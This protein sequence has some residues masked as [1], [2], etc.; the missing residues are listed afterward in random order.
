[1]TRIS[2]DAATMEELGEPKDGITIEGTILDI[3]YATMEGKVVIRVTVKGSDGRAYDLIDDEFKP[4]F[5]F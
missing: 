5:Y 4:Y 3:D 2:A 1:M